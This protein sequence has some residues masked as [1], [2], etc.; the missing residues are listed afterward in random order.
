MIDP[1]ENPVFDIA[2]AYQDTAALVAAVKLDIFTLIGPATVSLEDLMSRTGASQRGLRILCDY[3]TVLG[4]LKKRDLR[5]SLSPVART[6]LDG[7]SPFARGGIVDFLAAPEM[8]ELFFRD[9]VAYVHNG[10]SAEK[11]N[12]SPDNKVWVRYAES[13]TPFAAARIGCVDR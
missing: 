6:F 8:I 1:S 5:Y 7:S 9:P 13:M 2:M 11:G 4:L 10:G 12:T 3:L